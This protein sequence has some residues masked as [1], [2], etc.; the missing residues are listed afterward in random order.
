[1]T[2]ILEI[3]LPLGI[4]IIGAF[5]IYVL[6]RIFNLSNR[7]EALMAA[8]L[9]LAAMISM[10]LQIQRFP[11]ALLEPVWSFGNQESGGV[12][13]R[14]NALGIFVFLI[15]SMIAIL[16]CIYSGEYL[17]RDSRYLVYYPLILLTLAGL[18]GMFYSTDLFN[19]FLLTE[20]TT[21]TGSS[22]VA[23]RYHEKV[24]IS[25]GFKYLIMS[26]VGTMFMLLGIYFVFR[27]GGNLNLVEIS[28]LNFIDSLIR[29]GSACFL[30]G[31]ALKAGVVPL[32]TWV[33]DVYS[34]APSAVSGLLGGIISK[35]MLFMMPVIC[36]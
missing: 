7:F 29:I 6:T 26:S 27:Q 13:F 33:P 20:L 15:A 36:C 14:Q 4:L 28:M 12:L 17:S 11:Q 34:Y 22:L 19:L 21:I 30:M 10:V 9:L 24:A 5:S 25:A 8:A 3:I 16:V 32:H 18:L 35:S 2:G 23:F 31:F 1:V